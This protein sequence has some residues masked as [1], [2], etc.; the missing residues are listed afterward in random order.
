MNGD[1]AI[2]RVFIKFGQFFLAL[3]RSCKRLQRF[4][5]NTL[6]YNEY[7]VLV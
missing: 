5:V 6:L 1:I 2:N 3:F 7:N 4:N